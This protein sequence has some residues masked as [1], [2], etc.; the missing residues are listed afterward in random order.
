MADAIKLA[1]RLYTISKGKKTLALE[2]GQDAENNIVLS[3]TITK[4]SFNYIELYDGSEER[5]RL[6]LRARPGRFFYPKGGAPELRIGLPFPLAHYADGAD[7]LDL[8]SVVFATFQMNM[9]AAKMFAKDGSLK[10]NLKSGP[11]HAHGAPGPSKSI[12]G[13]TLHAL[14]NPSDP[15]EFE[16][17][18]FATSAPVTIKE[19]DF[20]LLT[21]LLRSPVGVVVSDIVPIPAD[22]KNFP[23]FPLPRSIV[24]RPVGIRRAKPKTEA[25]D[26]L[27][28]GAR[29]RVGR[30]KADVP[31][32]ATLVLDEADDWL[33]IPIRV[34]EDIYLDLVPDVFQ[35][36]DITKGETT[37]VTA[38]FSYLRVR[39]LPPQLFVKLW[40]EAIA[41][42]YLA[43]LR[44]IDDAADLSFVPVLK[45]ITPV[46]AGSAAFEAL[47]DIVQPDVGKDDQI[48]EIAIA[49]IR[50]VRQSATFFADAVF[51]GLIT[52]K[53]EKVVRRVKVTVEKQSI[54]DTYEWF[55]A[56]PIGSAK[57][58]INV[59]IEAR[60]NGAAGVG[61]LVRIGAFDLDVP[62]AATATTGGLRLHYAI[63]FDPLDPSRARYAAAGDVKGRDGR[64]RLP[65][66][67]EAVPRIRTQI[68][69]FDLHDVRP[70]AQ[71]PVPDSGRAFDAVVEDFASRDVEGSDPDHSR[72][73]REKRIARN[74]SRAASVVVVDGAGK[75]T[76]QATPFFLRG[77][78][79]TASK[80]N[81]QFTLTLH[82]VPEP[83]SGQDQQPDP[84]LETARRKRAIV[85]DC[86][87]FA[88]AMVDVPPLGAD[89]AAAQA[90][91]GE[92]ANW[93]L[94]EAGGAKWE[95]AGITE[96]FDLYFPPQ[97][98][99]EALEKGS[100]WTPISATGAETTID[101]RLGTVARLELQSS[102]YRQRYAE[103]PWNLRRVLGF[104]GDRA[105]GAALKTARF[106]Y[107]YGLGG[108]LSAPG[109]RLA[110]QGAR[111]GGIRD[112]LP[113]RP[114]GLTRALPEDETSRQPLVEAELYDRFRDVSASFAK[115]YGT[116]L[117]HFEP[118]REGSDDPL[119]IEEKVA[120]EL[121]LGPEAGMDMEPWKPTASPV[122]FGGGATRGFESKA[123]YEEV[124]SK[125]TSTRG[126]I[127]TPGFSALG[128]SGFVRA[129]FANGK[130]RIVSDTSIGRTHTYAIERIGRIGVF[131]NIAKHVIVYERTVLPHDQ[132]HDQQAGQHFGR[133]VVRKA[134]EYVDIIEPERAY[135]EKGAA[136]RSRGFVE[137]CLFRTRRIPVDSRWGHDVDDGWIVPLWRQDADTDLYPKPDVRLQLASAHAD[138][139]AATLSRLK[140][141]SQL[142]FFTSTRGG[143]G[144][145]PNLWAARENIDFVNT[146]SPMPVGMPVIDATD[147]DGKSADD[148]MRDP[149]LASCTFD[150]D[151]AGAAVNLV[152]ART[153]ADPV[154]A[155]LENVTMMRSA[156]TRQ[157]GG[158]A[159]RALTLRQEL[160]RILVDARRLEAVLDQA[161]T[162]ARAALA[163]L[164]PLAIAQTEAK[165]KAKVDV[166]LEARIAS[167]LVAEID[168]LAGLKPVVRREAAAARNAIVAAVAEARNALQ[169][170]ESGWTDAPK[171]VQERLWAGVETALLARVD[172]VC[173]QAD[174]IISGLDGYLGQVDPAKAEVVARWIEDALASVR[175]VIVAGVDQ[176][177]RPLAD[178]ERAI[179][180][181]KAEML[182]ARQSLFDKAKALGRQFREAADRGDVRSLIVGYETYHAAALATIDAA[183]TT[184]RRRLPRSIKSAPLF[185]GKTRTLDTYLTGLH[186]KVTSEHDRVVAAIQTEMMDAQHALKE[187]G[188]AIA[189]TITAVEDATNDLQDL[190]D[191]GHQTGEN[192]DKALGQ[193]TN[194]L[195]AVVATSID[196]IREECLK[197]GHTIATLKAAVLSQL[198][199]LRK[200]ADGFRGNAHDAARDL[201][202]ILGGVLDEVGNNV[203]DVVEALSNQIDKAN[204]A[205]TTTITDL[206]ND[207]VVAIDDGIATLKG[208]SGD[209]AAAIQDAAEKLKT[210]ADAIANGLRQQIPPAVADNIRVLEEG[211]KR[212]SKAPTFQNPSDTLALVRA[213][214]ASPILPNLTFNRERIAYFFDDARDAIRTSPV[215]ALMNRLDDDLKALGIRI[216][217]DEI[218]ERLIPKG[219]ENFDF[220]KLFPD[221]GGLKLDGLFKNLRMPAALN[222]RVKVT[223]GFDKASLSAWARA[224]ASSAFP[225]RS[226]IFEFGPLKLSMVGGRFDATANLETT[227]DG[228]T[229]RAARGDIVGDW[230]LAFSGRPLVTLE[231]TRVFFEDGKGLDVDINPARV[232][233]DRSIRFLSDL[234]KSYGAPD[235]GFFLEML[236]EQGMPAGVAARVDL[237]LPPLSFGAF[238]ATGLR[239]SS[240][241]ALQTSG[242]SGAKRGDFALST[243]LAIG[244]KSEPF[245]LRFWI[246]VGAG[247]LETRAKYFPT[248]GK[249]SSAVSIGLTAGLGLDF[250]FGPCRGFAYAMFGVY[251]E[252]ENDGGSGKNFSIAVIFV[253]RGGIV[254]LGRFNIGL[255]LLLELVYRD[256]GT[257]V[258]RGTIEVSFRICWCC[259][260][261]VRQGVTYH[262]SKTSGKAKAAGKPHYLD[263][264]A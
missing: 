52:H 105:P 122:G 99:G 249:L 108:R 172:T 16:R 204:V 198:N 180:S 256:D 38:Y 114:Y 87:P 109:L 131:W 65:R 98:T 95:I 64:A 252:F 243:A 69:R 253:V 235:S 45:N 224:E 261:K 129:F 23:N 121:R 88:V 55:D 30:E 192:A 210:G 148:L 96:G 179:S 159:G 158:A 175:Q 163:N 19:R 250:A 14:S 162:T 138:A 137:A 212:L 103:A 142:V 222:D 4:L 136:P 160:E 189:A 177:G 208:Y 128:G 206:E 44:T 258:G 251:A 149:L 113:A 133:P 181:F 111:I 13:V 247:W 135:P 75:K 92:F 185:S 9:L 227:P 101:Y 223:D 154:G 196:L 194:G 244:R 21:R 97:A 118:Y 130:T 233:L 80:K 102:Y 116:R 3:K 51:P 228:V 141:P 255:S 11:A 230:E 71:D 174:T 164:A 229:K 77:R 79:M 246:L 32:T 60:A 123:I 170:A 53:G 18:L 62:S 216:P 217:T 61:G 155:V 89:S 231:Q 90:N 73:V 254:V 219:M 5:L 124:V 8:S 145:D 20:P 126:Q 117:A 144:D 201:R 47:Y 39:P 27:A 238:S 168:R 248:S 139:A 54:E 218:L 29:I 193:L 203:A 220:G 171:E 259:E 125:P 93:E 151:S 106:E 260:I 112:P 262:L 190:V 43:A 182:A 22:P 263:S 17:R 83:Q 28:F 34:D 56:W 166:E 167:A 74:L 215:V 195:D 25:C 234:I 58:E 6:S 214:G 86:E 236:E 36:P 40:N 143:D 91:D 245:V 37:A 200:N 132:F 31:G 100:P 156:A 240:T 242:D 7:R 207:L 202:A 186:R 84:A 197:T 264:F 10:L 42:P 15:H 226:E 57:P 173:R 147:P 119:S 257:A 178:L 2:V 140:D 120:F 187:I 134:R 70:G 66:A 209:L 48:A 35:Q 115:V 183:G 225:D 188:N 12:P 237:P 157:A 26:F 221:L 211:Y 67:G 152:N 241:F 68:E 63:T 213:A 191:L 94:S 82:R 169:D 184:A 72:V 1:M 24:V 76:P 127:I 107:L 146:P 232:R 176:L 205:A 150:L 49:A 81:R 153:P 165:S 46:S 104:A 85:V 41:P 33:D 161:L 59:R 239:F 199:C 50:P 78:E 110:E